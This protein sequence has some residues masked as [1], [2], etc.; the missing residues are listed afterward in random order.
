M[1]QCYAFQMVVYT[2]KDKPLG[3]GPVFG[4]MTILRKF[5]STFFVKD[6]A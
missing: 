1:F 6:D 4:F 3:N 5:F 2:E